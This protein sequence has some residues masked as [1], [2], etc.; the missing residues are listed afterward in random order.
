MPP[1]ERILSAYSHVA[2]AVEDLRGYVSQTLK[3]YCANNRYL[4]FDRVK[5]PESLSE[6]LEGGRTASWSKI[7]DLYGCTIVVP[8]ANH[9]VRVIRKLDACF[10]KRSIKSR[11]TTLKAPD[12]FRFDATRYYCTLTETAAMLRTPGAGKQIFE[13]QIVTAFEYAWTSVTH[14]LIYKGDTADW[15]KQRLAAQLKAA[16]EQIEMIIEAFDEVSAAVAPSAWPDVKIRS[17]VIETF[18]NLFTDGVLDPQLKPI[19]WSRFADN[20]VALTSSY[21]ESEAKSRAACETLLKEVS[22]FWRSGGAPDSPRSGS[23][24]QLI[25]GHVGKEG[26]L[27]SLDNFI[28]VESSELADLYAL[29]GVPKPFKF[30]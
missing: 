7:D 21:T 24:F 10:S 29:S 3:G 11:G 27:G 19:S 26:T 13:V 20:V 22:T 5:S 30:D 28:V 6:K 25:L 1:P 16:V 18:Q 14:D 23:L 8:T 12:V 2:G 17:Q 4:F 15:R 9:E